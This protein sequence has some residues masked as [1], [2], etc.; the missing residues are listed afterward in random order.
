MATIKNFLT[1]ALDRSA[2]IAG[3]A[4]DWVKGKAEGLR[5]STAA[6][7]AE[8]APAKPLSGAA[9][10]AVH[11]QEYT[12][13][14][15]ADAFKEAPNNAKTW[16]ASTKAAVDAEFGKEGLRQPAKASSVFDPAFQDELKASNQRVRGMGN[17]HLATAEG[18]AALGR[19]QATMEQFKGEPRQI[20]IGPVEGGK[21]AAAPKAG[22]L[23]SGLRWAGRAVAPIAAI[24][25]GMKATE[26]DTVEQRAGGGAVRGGLA[27]YGDTMALGYGRE[28]GTALGA[29]AAG[30]MQGKG[31]LRQRLGNAYDMAKQGWADAEAAEGS[32]SQPVAPRAA[33]VVAPTNGQAPIEGGGSL[34]PVAPRAPTVADP[35]AVLRDQDYS[36][37]PM[38]MGVISRNGEP[39]RAFGTPGDYRGENSYVA[40]DR[41]RP[42]MRDGAIPEAPNG[43]FGELAAMQGLRTRLGQ[44]RYGE[45]VGVRQRGQ[46][47][48]MRGQDMSAAT[49]ERGQNV[50]MR[51]QTLEAAN[52][53]AR[54]AHDAGKENAASLDKQIDA[55]ADRA[56]PLAESGFFKNTE[57][58]MKAREEAKKQYGNELRRRINHSLGDRTDG[59]RLENL[60]GAEFN[61]LV[62]ADKVRRKV[63]DKRGTLSQSVR[64]FFGAKQFDSDNLYGYMPT[65]AVPANDG[66]FVLHFGNGNTAKADIVGGDFK[67]LS[68][69]APIDA[70]I[71]QLV[72]PLV[73]AER[74]RLDKERKGSK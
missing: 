33:P 48:V 45:G 66:G 14:M 28:L 70:D 46:D 73:R 49:A 18:Q 2:A 74:A 20:K 16:N 7:A 65:K 25:A 43:V 41:V 37:V 19:S 22:M 69:N 52:A 62:L 60:S 42:G 32:A 12:K 24:D 31:G 13:N 17:P 53:R 51:G 10:Q 8:P 4:A 61:Q 6:P 9:R 11:G 67:W 27:E 54:L 39:A 30:F 64:D 5:S 56:T 26:G 1:Q 59:K 36:A 68:P 34:G 29:G 21:A 15:G 44:D 23:R 55:A 50:T 63:E 3:D 57:N 35:A 40:R 72:A 58:S 38:G 47:I 71:Q